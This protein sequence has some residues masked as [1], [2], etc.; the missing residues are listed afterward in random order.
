[1]RKVLLQ[2]GPSVDGIVAGG[3]T[4]A[5]EAGA[6][7]ED[8]A[9]KRWKVQSLHEVGTHIMGR[10][11]YEQMASHWPYNGPAEY[12]DLMNSIPKVVFSKTLTKAEWNESLIARGDLSEEI[13]NLRNEPGK[14]I[15]V[16]GG[17][18]FVQALSRHGLID[19][20]RLVVRP[21]ALGS[22]MPL[23]K[24]LLARLPLRLVDSKAF[25]DG[26]AIWVYESIRSL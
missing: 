5:G 15:M 1:M 18:R 8:E 2:M 4:E 13:A 7:E 24:D 22:G 20:Y 3:P 17:A 25:A 14:D 26:T 9:V 21:V 11:T 19:E 10:V 6:T 23:F 16:H 12:A